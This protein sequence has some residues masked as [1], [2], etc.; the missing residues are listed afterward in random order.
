MVKNR[1]EAAVRKLEKG[2][3][4]EA[5]RKGRSS[6]TV[7]L[8]NS[9]TMK[10]GLAEIAKECNVTVPEGSVKGRGPLLKALIEHVESN[11]SESD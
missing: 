7:E 10:D 8:M 4:K 5:L 9:F 6:V 3:A 1:W 2:M 11:E